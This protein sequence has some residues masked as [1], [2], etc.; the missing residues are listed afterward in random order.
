VSYSGTALGE[1]CYNVEGTVTTENVTSSLQMGTITLALESDGN[2][3]FSGTGSLVGNITGTTGDLPLVT[4]L[5]S[6]T[7][8]FPQGTSF[9]TTDDAADLSFAYGNP[10]RTYDDDG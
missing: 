4:T 7:A 6:H 9:V 3:A 2:T 8:R 1:V 5:L 10:V